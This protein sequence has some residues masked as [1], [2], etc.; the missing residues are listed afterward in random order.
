MPER[1]N[2]TLVLNS[3]Q[4]LKRVI[5]TPKLLSTILESCIKKF[6]AVKKP[7]L[8]TPSGSE[9]T[10]QEDVDLHVVN[11][12]VLVV[13]NG[14]NFIGVKKAAGSDDGRVAA[15]VRIIA[16]VS[17]VDSIAV[18]QLE[19]TARLPGVRYAIGMPD[20]HAGNQF[21]IGTVI[22]TENFVYPALIGGDIG[23]GMSLWTTSIPSHSINPARLASKLRD[24][25]GAWDGDA[26]QWLSEN[27]P[28]F[29]A[30]VEEMMSQFHDSLGTVGGGNHFAELQVAASIV[31]REAFESLGLVEGNAC[32]LVHT[33]SR[34]F[35]TKILQSQPHGGLSPNTP[36]YT[37]YISLHDAALH[38]AK[39]NRDLVAHR[40]LSCINASSSA[41]RVIDI[42]HNNVTH[43]PIGDEQ[44]YM[45]RKGAAPSDK[46]AIVIP[47][48]R[49]DLSYLVVPTAQ[50]LENGFSLAHGAG[51]KLTRT[52]ALMRFKDKYRGDAGRAALERTALGSVVVCDGDLWYEESPEAYKPVEGIIEDLKE[53][54]RVV[55]IL[56]PVVTYKLRRE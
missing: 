18:K 10:C 26:K 48:S 23:C 21:P 20:L 43:Q 15:V 4:T 37:S 40:F 2:L 41:T 3:N 22:I 1:I 17:D 54:C 51:R 8:F 55:A 13:S 9:I 46:G 56:K 11:Q 29:S 36:E 24:L 28:S 25:E 50:G 7:R 34:G 49:G 52:D 27:S 33:G 14:E 30:E 53:Y 47:G 5:I 38:Y 35:G 42:H 32:L 6:P 39:R 31:D 19:Q 45:H 12:C 44:L 16:D